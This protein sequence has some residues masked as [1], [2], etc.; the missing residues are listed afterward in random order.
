[1]KKFLTLPIA[2]LMLTACSD[3]NNTPQEQITNE[4]EV[5]SFLNISILTPKSSTR[6]DGEDDY[7]NGSATENNINNIRFYFFYDGGDAAPVWKQAASNN[8]LSYIDWTPTPGD[9][10]DGP[11]EGQTVEKIVS[12]TLGINMPAENNGYPDLILAIINPTPELLS[13]KENLTLGDLTSEVND[14]YTG[15]YNNNFVITNS[16]YSSGGAEPK[17]INA[18]PI[19]ENCFQPTIEETEGNE[20]IIYVERVLARLDLSLNIEKGVKEITGEGGS[21]YTIY[22]V[23]TETINNP[24]STS[25]DTYYSQDIYVH[26]LGW[27]I[28]QTPSASNLI[29]NINVAWSTNLFGSLEPW[30]SDNYHRSFWAINPSKD[31]FS[32]LYGSWDKPVSGDGGNYATAL[33]MP[34]GTNAESAYL[35]ENA[36]PLEDSGSGPV[37][38]TEVIMAAQLVDVNGNPL[39]LIRWAN[40]YY[41]E[42]GIK[43]TVANALELYSK[44]ENTYTKITPSQLQFVT[45]RDIYGDNMPAT[46]ADY[47]VYVQL[48]EA[49]QG[50]TW[51]DGNT[52]TATAYTNYAAVNNYIID[53]TNYM[54]VWDSGQTYYYFEIQHLGAEDSPGYYGVVR[55]HLYK[56]NITSI[57]GLGTPVYDPEQTIIPEK[58]DG[59]DSVLSV[60]INILQWR[61]VTN[62]YSI[63]WP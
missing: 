8:Y 52:D 42:N 59:D 22:Q 49:A 26:F 50:L 61:V 7:V 2:V 62:Y 51:Y 33:P 24:G 6:V 48:T 47:Y 35:Q 27:N 1:M 56:A 5:R 57:A 54:M 23:G 60:K 10:E 63:E 3:H 28:T 13:I 43:N 21:S 31:E 45:A 38:P 58:P 40:R 34:A 12:A 44:S 30:N 41:T 25:E 29:K 15:L 36:A 9:I 4:G 20:L 14:Y 53:R 37:M 55:N 19:D 46:E 18:T 11:V 16:V 32:Y 39:T 17:L